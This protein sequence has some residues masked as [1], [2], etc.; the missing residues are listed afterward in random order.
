MMFIE[1]MRT[2]FSR[3]RKS[4][5]SESQL[6]DEGNN[7]IKPRLTRRLGCPRATRAGPIG[8]PIG[9]HEPLGISI[10]GVT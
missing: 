6:V 5:A 3:S 7:R 1:D 10:I 4:G 2:G 8:T 9:R